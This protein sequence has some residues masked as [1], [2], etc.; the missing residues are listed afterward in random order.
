MV[1]IAFPTEDEF[2]FTVTKLFPDPTLEPIAPHL[3]FKRA[4]VP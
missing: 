4:P 2:Q 1:S 3:I